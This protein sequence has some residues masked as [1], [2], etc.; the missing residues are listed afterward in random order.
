M[1]GRTTDAGLV[2]AVSLT[3]ATCTCWP[4]GPTSWPGLR[5]SCTRW[6]K[7]TRAH[8]LCAG[9]ARPVGAGGNRWS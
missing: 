8:Q 3:C 9:D 4:C 2:P 5:I 7:P 6:P 1:A